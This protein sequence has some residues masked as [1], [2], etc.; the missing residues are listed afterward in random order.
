MDLF[1]QK[2]PQA[3]FT[4]HGDMDNLI[5]IWGSIGAKIRQVAADIKSI[6]S[7]HLMTNVNQASRR[8]RILF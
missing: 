4:L 5:L 6:R 8:E 7:G 1:D 3:L 2:K